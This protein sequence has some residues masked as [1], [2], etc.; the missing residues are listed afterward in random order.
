MISAMKKTIQKL[1]A[2]KYFQA[3]IEKVA[4]GNFEGAVREFT[5]AVEA[6]PDM[7]DAY[8]FRGNAHLDNNDNERA[9]ADLNYVIEKSP[10]HH[11]AHYN[12]SIAWMGLDQKDLA[13]AD[14]NKA[15]ELAPIEGAYYLHRSVVHLLREEYDLALEDATRA[16][17]LGEA[18][19][20]INN[21]AII[22]E[23]KGD[24]RSALADW[25]RL[26]EVEPNNA[27]ARC[28]RGL[29]LAANGDRAAAVID[30]TSALK[31]NAQLADPLR[32]EAEQTLQR[33]GG[34]P[35]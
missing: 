17:D 27:T 22:Y 24:R 11:A 21:R 34:D 1:K 32:A 9:I 7:L 30:L 6:D 19:M 33:L 16:I 20:G 5:R 31:R 4:K 8:S 3:G 23:K 14:M 15:I 10:D 28:R 29:L 25:T 2:V 26:L 13:L 12:R 18:R 35:S